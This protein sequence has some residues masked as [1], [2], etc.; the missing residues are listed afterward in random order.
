MKTTQE[1][2]HHRFSCEC[3]TQMLNIDSPCVTSNKMS[4]CYGYSEEGMIDICVFTALYD[5]YCIYSSKCQG[6]KIFVNWGINGSQIVLHWFQNVMLGCLDRPVFSV[7]VNTN[8]I[9][10]IT[11]AHQQSCKDLSYVIASLKSTKLL[12]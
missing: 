12:Q 6:H 4:C 5:Y 9:K 11:A 2:S 10:L 3:G 7:S 8:V 1:Q